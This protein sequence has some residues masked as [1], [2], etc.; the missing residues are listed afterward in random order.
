M[1]ATIL[2]MLSTNSLSAFSLNATAGRVGVG[3]AW[4]IAPVRGDST[5]QAAPGTATQP[6]P[7]SLSGSASG[8]SG[9][10]APG[11]G[12]SVRRGSLIDLSV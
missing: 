3:Q 1:R 7:Q 2:R 12:Q 5:V 8:A 6:Q 10:T 9:T 11:G 4:P